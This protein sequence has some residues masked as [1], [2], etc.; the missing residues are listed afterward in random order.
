MATMV[1]PRYQPLAAE[2][3]A[4]VRY[5]SWKHWPVNWT[6][7]WS[8]R[9]VGVHDRTDLWT[10]RHRGRRATAW[11]GEPCGLAHED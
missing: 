9:I 8:G 2:N 3:A 7:V 6:A 5:Q 1:E 11:T 4:E 10:D